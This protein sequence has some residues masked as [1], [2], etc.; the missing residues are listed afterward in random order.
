[1]SAPL[2]RDRRGARLSGARRAPTGALRNATGQDRGAGEGRIGE[3]ARDRACGAQILVHAQR[4]LTLDTESPGHDEPRGGARD[5][6]QRQ[7][8]RRV[9]LGRVRQERGS[10][11]L[12]AACFGAAARQDD[13]VPS[14]VPGAATAAAWLARGAGRSVDAVATFSSKTRRAAW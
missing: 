12:Q 4:W 10:F 11:N 13:R 3:R 2:D 5:G 1:R 7:R 6:V 14:L 9:A 8:L